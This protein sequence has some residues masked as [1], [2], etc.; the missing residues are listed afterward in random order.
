MKKSAIVID[1]IGFSYGI[2]IDVYL[3]QKTL[4]CDVV[5]V[6]CHDETRTYRP[7]KFRKVYDELLCKYDRLY[8]DETE[9]FGFLLPGQKAANQQIYY[10]KHLD[11]SPVVDHTAYYQGLH[12]VDAVIAKTKDV[13]R[14]YRAIQEKFGY[15]FQII[16]TK[17]TS[18]D[19]SKVLAER[20]HFQVANPF[21][22]QEAVIIPAHILILKE[23][24]LPPTIPTNYV[25]DG[26]FLSFGR[27]NLPMITSFWNEHQNNDRLP[28]LYI[29]SYCENGVVT[30]E[31][32]GNLAACKANPKIEILDR[33]ISESEKA[34]LY[35]RCTFFIN[36][37]PSEGYGH[38]INEARSTGRIILV[39]D[40][41]PM[42]ELI[43][44]DCGIIMSSIGDGVSRAIQLSKEEVLRK[45]KR[46]RERYVEDTESFQETFKTIK[47]LE[48][49][50]ALK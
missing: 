38:N 12:L 16:S 19:Y 2:Y 34:E 25:G 24:P 36:A 11:I 4:E 50:Q 40:R 14:Y 22:G 17:F 26:S 30:E 47:K 41:E 21:K 32:M 7:E 35:N 46:T 42:N 9:F 37:S 44:P 33:Y 8:F 6:S 23:I 1:W 20:V 3:Y 13:E 45:M 49:L 43:D 29:K 18:L 31:E 27:K 28:K 10:S 48:I 15:S 5:W 39:F